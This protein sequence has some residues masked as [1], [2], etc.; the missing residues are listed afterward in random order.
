MT[1]YKKRVSK[2]NEKYIFGQKDVHSFSEVIS[3]AHCIS[4]VPT[5]HMINSLNFSLTLLELKPHFPFKCS[6]NTIKLPYATTCKRLHWRSPTCGTFLIT[7]NSFQIFS[8]LNFSLL[9]TILCDQYF[10]FF[11]NNFGCKFIS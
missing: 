10:N 2:F 9:L 3:L 6:P 8:H 1:N 11:V 4:F 5:W 7:W